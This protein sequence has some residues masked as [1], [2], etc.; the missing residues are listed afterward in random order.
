MPSS[1]LTPAA[2]ARLPLPGSSRLRLPRV[3]ALQL[4]RGHVRLLLA[5]VAVAGCLGGGWLALRDSRLVA[6]DRVS[7]HGVSGPEADEIRGALRAAGQ[8]MTTL[9]VR[10]TVL[11]SAVAPYAVVKSVTARP[12]FPHGLDVDVVQRVPVAAL[13]AGGHA[14]PVAGDGTLLP[15]TPAAGLAQV[16]LRLAPAGDAV[17]DR[18]TLSTVRLLA[19]APA[20][21]RARVT[22]AFRGADGLTVHLAEG[23]AVRFGP[24]TRLTAK[25]A[26]L[27]AVLASRLS[28]G[29][30][31]IDVRVP[32][33]PAA[34]GLEQGA[35][36]LGQPSTSAGG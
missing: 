12:R 20:P 34:A 17:T 31:A 13:L 11:T 35:A 24:A 7:V 25:W 28:R 1:R 26:S 15:G 36:Q 19:A 14:V 21:L 3:R 4:R 9:H 18:R 8:D 22:T 32:E 29:A 30:T 16:K 27:T 10:P 33:H 2:S 23:P 6:V 5:L